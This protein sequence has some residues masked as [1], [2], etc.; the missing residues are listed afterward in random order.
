MALF[1]VRHHKSFLRKTSLGGICKGLA[2]Q[3]FPHTR[4]VLANFK[5]KE[6][7]LCTGLDTKGL[8]FDN[9]LI[10][11]RHANVMS[12]AMDVYLIWLLPNQIVACLLKLNTCKL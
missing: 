12:L 9:Q 10:I 5:F 1:K 8:R 11:S 4:Y 3:I 7:L 2:Q 6:V